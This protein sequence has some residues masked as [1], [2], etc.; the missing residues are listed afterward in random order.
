MKLFGFWICLALTVENSVHLGLDI[1][2]KENEED[3]LRRHGS[4][5]EEDAQSP[6]PSLLSS[7]S[8]N[9][10]AENISFSLADEKFVLSPYFLKVGR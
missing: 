5:T 1:H 2:F 6:Y 3:M 8:L 9:A 7:S 10:M 4:G